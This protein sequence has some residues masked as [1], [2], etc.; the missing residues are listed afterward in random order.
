MVA[1]DHFWMA[2]GLLLGGLWHRLPSN[3][4]F[5]AQLG[6]L[7]CHFNGFGSL[8]VN[9]GSRIGTNCLTKFETKFEH[10][11]VPVLK[12]KAR[13]KGEC[14]EHPPRRHYQMIRA[15]RCRKDCELRNLIDLTQYQDSMPPPPSLT[16]VDNDLAHDTPNL[17]PA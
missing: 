2:F 7:G 15:I 11:L 4:D 12:V 14:K 6:R 1:L 17:S 13:N 16:I 9:L 10:K 8:F 5:W 3:L